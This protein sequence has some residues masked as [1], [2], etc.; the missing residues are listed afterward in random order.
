MQISNAEV[1]A[2]RAGRETVARMRDVADPKFRLSVLARF[3]LAGPHGAVDLPNKKLAGLLAYLA[4]T[5]PAP[6]S[7]EKLEA[8]L[9]GS[10]FQTQARQNLRQ[11][12]FRLRR[13]LGPGALIS[14][15]DK[16]ALA[17]GVIDCDAV[18]LRDLFGEGSR[19]SLAAAADL[20][21]DRFLCDI[22]IAEEAWTDWLT[23]ERTRLERL[24]LD[25]MVRHAEQT[26]QTGDAEQALKVASRAIVVNALREDAHRLIIQALAAAG[27]KPEALK[28]YQDL[29]ALLR[30]ELNTEPDS[31]TRSLVANIGNV[32]VL[33]PRT[34]AKTEVVA[35]AGDAEAT[36]M[37]FRAASLERRQLTVLVCRIVDS[38]ELSAR[39]DPEEMHNRIAEFHTTVA[40][41]VSRFGGFVA[42]Y[43]SD[44]VHVY[45]G[46]PAAHEHDADQ[47]VRGALAIQDA[48]GA[49]SAP[50]GEKLQ[51]SVG[52]A[53]GLVVVS[54]QTGAGETRQRVAI[55]E[56]PNVAAQLQ[57]AAASGE[58]VIAATTRRLVGR[59]FD[60]RELGSGQQDE[61]QAWQ[62]LGEAAG[63]SRFDARRAD[64]LST[65]VGRQEEI[66]LLRR[67]WDQAKSGEG[68]V[69]LVSGE[70]GIGKSRLVED[71]LKRLADEKH[72]CLQFSCSPHHAH[73]P[74]Y[75]FIEQ[76]ERNVTLDLSPAAKLDRL[77][78]L[79]QPTAGDVA[80]DVALIAELLAAPRDERDRADVVSS[81][82]KRELTLSAL[83]AQLAG[84]A[85]ENPVLVV[86]EDVQWIDPTSLD[87]LNRTVARI[88]SLPVL[89]LAT[90]RPEFQPAWIGEPHVSALP[91]SRLGRRDSAAL[92]GGVAGGT[93]LPD[94]VVEQIVAQTDG[95]PLFVEELTRTVLESGLLRETA[96]GFALDGPLPALAIPTSLRASLVSRLDRLGSA[97]DIALIAAAIGREFSHELL[98]AIT[99]LS[100]AELD[101][102]LERLTASGLIS[103]RGT[104]PAAT[105]MFK[106]ALVQDAAYA[107]LLKSRRR[108]L[109]ANI[110]KVLVERFPAIVER[111]PE[112]VAHHLTE[113][114]EAADAVD[115]WRKAGQL[116]SLR[117]AAREAVTFFEQALQL[118][119]RLPESEATL[120]QGCDVRLKLQP[121]LLELGQSA[122]MMECLRE[123][124]ALAER[125]NDGR[126]RGRILAFMTLAHTLRGEPGKALATGS[127]A[128][129]SAARF[130]DLRTRII[131]TSQLVQVHHA[132]GEY[133]RAIE[134][135]VSNLAALPSDWVHE[136]FGTGGPPA[137]W[138]RG[139]LVLSLT[140][141]GRFTEAVE[142][143]AE[144]IRLAEPTKHAFTVGWAY[145]AAG[146]LPVRRGDWAQALLRY[147]RVIALSKASKSFFLLPLAL[148]PIPWI[149]AQLGRTNEAAE[150]LNECEQFVARQTARGGSLGVVGPLL[151][152]MGHAALKL[153]RLDDAQRLG[154]R[155][156]EACEHHAGYWAEALH[157]QAEVATHRDL[158]DADSGEG[159]YRKALELATSRSMRPLIAHCRFGLGKIYRQNGKRDD[160]R[161]ELSTAI[162]M[163]REM[164]MPFW[165]NE[166][167][168]VDA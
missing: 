9:W 1:D 58:I 152:W 139:R 167:E 87:L 32:V 89:L 127:R 162:A 2:R 76:I 111:L 57:A 44:G 31:L 158:F 30:R 106:H 64:A 60:C 81:Q 125:L 33:Q 69:V 161:N 20:Y 22:N 65:L 51:V 140:A 122:R 91:L 13:T 41:T 151:P 35:S 71:L 123:A 26:L 121:V 63:V 160:A 147:E 119:T 7:R 141:V 3:T 38:L 120:A 148:A 117:S 108:A 37:A 156:V 129:E 29:V 146:S 36:A 45:F 4:C 114:A 98:A 93:V 16:V 144:A 143:A 88:A 112:V 21:Q 99:S 48:I 137:I 85:A 113:A 166:A 50:T 130:D 131:A 92:V 145:F 159:Y 164:D 116:A 46:Y 79:F 17:P 54:D 155:A 90:F 14:E 25:A 24:A 118:L 42:Q 132:R 59:A 128:L 168:S 34:E 103:R 115:Y 27:R 100:A 10:H 84:L 157:L 15:G 73:S 163:Y 49:L 39:L 150:R 165:L 53:T 40:D 96:N 94:A 11:A 18:R 74:L 12:L 86:V 104:P 95:V 105:Y 101:A 67:R 110:A 23:A 126:R 6:Q 97:R 66:D 70:P 83:I 62:V 56:A 109:H 80:Q 52:I 47:A 134:L 133:D 8:L 136:T 154:A 19:A 72:S 55:G 124:D 138:D 142:P 77:R 153:G 135:A 149:L 43:L 107:C 82:Q 61:T 75:P 68:R 102:A 5:A 78:A 28:H